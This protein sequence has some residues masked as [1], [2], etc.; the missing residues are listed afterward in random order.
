MSGGS[1]NYI[2]SPLTAGN[3]LEIIGNIHE[4]EVEE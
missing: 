1:M 4:M 2:S 3:D